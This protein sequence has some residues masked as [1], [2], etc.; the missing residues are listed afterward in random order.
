[1]GDDQGELGKGTLDIRSLKIMNNILGG[2]VELFLR[3]PRS[4]ALLY[5]RAAGELVARV[6]D[7]TVKNLPK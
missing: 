4:R 1:L 2:L 5:A 3:A 7:P 6:V